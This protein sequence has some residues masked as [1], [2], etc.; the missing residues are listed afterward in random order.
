MIAKTQSH[1]SVLPTLANPFAAV[2]VV[3]MVLAGAAATVTFDLF[4]QALS[5]MAGFARLA[6]VGL[7]DA[8]LQAVFGGKVAGGGHLLHVIAGLLAYPLGWLLLAPLA[9]RFAPRIPRYAVA[10]GYGVALW[11]FALFVMAYLVA[12][13]PAFLGFTGIT[14][15]ALIGH[16]VY[17]V[18]LV[19]ALDLQNR[20]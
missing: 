7:A 13:L 15:I 6:P 1:A 19:G 12:G 17:A 2:S 11:V 9:K 14:W 20:R 4:G 16:V 18:A 3:S 10:V 8:T 5:P